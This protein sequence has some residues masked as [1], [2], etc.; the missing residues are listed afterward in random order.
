MIFNSMGWL[1]QHAL[2]R[3]FGDRSVQVPPG[4][5]LFPAHTGIDLALATGTSVLALRDGIVLFEGW[6]GDGLT[7]IF[8]KLRFADGST[9]LAAHLSQTSVNIGQAVVA[10]QQIGL[11]GGTRGQG[12]QNWA[13]H[14]HYEEADRNGFYDPLPLYRALDIVERTYNLE[15][16]IKAIKDRLGVDAHH[17]HTTTSWN[18]GEPI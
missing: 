1:L 18:T 4:S 16:T 12:L 17:K 7:G 11:S 10:G 2:T 8:V 9:G 15:A 13:P 6:S 14:L 5:G 3:G